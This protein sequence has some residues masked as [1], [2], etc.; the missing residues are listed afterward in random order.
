MDQ[1][2]LKSQGAVNAKEM[3]PLLT[4]FLL[5]GVEMVEGERVVRVVTKLKIGSEIIEMYMVSL[6]RADN[7]MLLNFC[8]W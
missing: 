4:L 2:S 5:E 3:P 1:P 8:K 7:R 6:I